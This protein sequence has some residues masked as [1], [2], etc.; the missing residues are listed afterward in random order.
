V[1]NEFISPSFAKEGV[2]DQEFENRLSSFFE[3]LIS[4]ISEAKKLAQ[5]KG[6]FRANIGTMW[7]IGEFALHLKT[8][9][10]MAVENKLY[11]DQ[12]VDINAAREKL[13]V[14]EN[15]IRKLP[16]E[17]PEMDERQLDELLKNAQEAKKILLVKEK[18]KSS[19]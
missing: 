4:N 3:T 17:N 1:Y 11:K 8:L 15:A 5:Q 14:I 10:Q 2:M 18:Q 16:L 9:C 13:T 12:N 6:D 7:R 19:R